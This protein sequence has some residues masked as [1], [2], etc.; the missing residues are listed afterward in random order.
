MSMKI[1]LNYARQLWL[2]LLLLVG[3]AAIAVPGLNGTN[4][5]GVAKIDGTEYGT[6]QD[7]LDAAHGMVGNVTITLTNDITGYGIVHQKEGLN[8]TI[9]G[10]DKKI[11]GNI[12]IDGNNNASGTETLTIQNI[13]F[14]DDGSNFCGPTSAF[15]EVPGLKTTGTPYYNNKNNYAHNIT[16]SNCTFTNTGS[17][18]IVGFKS[19]NGGGNCYNLVMNNVS[20]ANLH[21]FAQLNSSV[22]ATFDNCEATSTGNFI[23]ITGGDGD[24][25]ISNCSFPSSKIGGY[26]IRIKSGSNNKPRTLTL[27]GNN[28]INADDAIIVN[29][30][31]Y[32]TVSV[33]NGTYKGNISNTGTAKLTISGGTFSEAVPAS[34]LAEGYGSFGNADGTFTVKVGTA[35]AKIGDNKMYE[36]LETAFAAAQDG[37]TITL[38]KDCTGNGI[39]V[40]T[41]KYATGVTV[42]FGGFT[43]TVDGTTVGSTGTQTQ[44]FHLEKD[45]KFTFKNGTI[46]SENAKMLVQNYSDLTL[47]GMTLTMNNANYAS[48]YT[49]SNNCGNVVINNTTIKANPAGGFA[50]DVCRYSSYP[51]V[52]VTV[53]GTSEIN[54]DVEVSASGSDAKDGFSLMLEAGT[55]TG[56]IVLDASAKTAMANTPPS[57]RTHPL[58]TSGLRPVKVSASSLPATT[59]PRSVMLS[60][61]HSRLHSPL[62]RTDRPSPC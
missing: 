57:R 4:S 45:N 49:L 18:D 48:A 10:A 6:L 59:S 2:S 19:N 13:K 40:G 21:S 9:D 38:L 26:G 8:L 58:T 41:G 36:S 28:N 42:D 46:T 15:V 39:F 37:E 47:E 34:T 29:S 33:E 54:G 53:K 52:S 50:F 60:S 32:T 30:D 14:F 23:S 17:N 3:V 1:K 12:V 7:A 25:V 56:N 61:R 27:K 62:S 16:I 5:G 35:V 43:Y 55:M 44:A 31:Q 22:N 24:L 11:T 51:S 20:G